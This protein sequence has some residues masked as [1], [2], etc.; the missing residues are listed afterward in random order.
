MVIN[1]LPSEYQ[2]VEYLES[3]GEE[4]IDSGV[5]PDQHLSFHCKFMAYS[6]S[7]P[8]FGNVF[9]SR[10]RSGLNE[11]QLTTYLNGII[12]V[13]AR[14]QYIGFYANVINTIDFDGNSIATVNGVQTQLSVLDELY[15]RSIYLFAIREGDYVRQL[16]SGRIYEL[17][18]GNIANFI[19]CYRK[20][21]SEPGMYDTVRNQFFTNSGTGRFLV[22]NDVSH[23]N[24]NLME[25]RR[26]ILLNTPHIKSLSDNSLNFKSDMGYFY[27]DFKIHFGPVQDLNGYY[28]PWPAGGGTIPFDGIFEAGSLDS[29]GLNRSLNVGLRTPGYIPIQK[30]ATYT[31]TVGS[32]NSSIGTI[33][34]GVSYYSTNDFVTER[35]RSNFN[36]Y[37]SI[38]FTIQSNE[39]IRYVRFEV[40]FIGSDGYSVLGNLDPSY[41]SDVQL[42]SNLPESNICPISGWDGVEVT[43]CG[44][45]VWDEQWE[46]GN[47]S[48]T[49]GA[50]LNA[51]D[52]IRSKN[53]I[54]ICP[55]TLYYASNVIIRF[56][57]DKN[58]NFLYYVGQAS[59]SFTTPANAYYMR[60]RTYQ[61]GATYNNDISINYLATATS[62]EPYQGET[63]EIPLVGSGKNLY[64]GTKSNLRS[65]IYGGRDNDSTMVVEDW[66]INP[67]TYTISF[68]VTN[69]T[70]H[71]SMFIS[72]QID[73]SW[74]QSN[75]GKVDS[76]TFTLP[77]GY[78]RLNIW[79]YTGDYTGFT[80]IQLEKGSVATEYEPYYTLSSDTVYGGTVDLLTGEL[81]VDRAMVDMGTMT[82]TYVATSYAVPIFSSSILGI[83]AKSS[84]KCITSI[85]TYKEGGW[86]LHPGSDK[87][88]GV[89][90]NNI[91]VAD[92]QYTSAAAFKTA[93]SGVQLVYELA[94]PQTYQL[95]PE[96]IRTLKGINN[97]FSNAN[98]NIDISFYSH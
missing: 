63:I 3:T 40:T 31:L 51:N 89:G 71:P 66:D 59:G 54:P 38:T 12:S 49:T 24:V 26:R 17:S 68:E 56:Y 45:N 75:K 55:S 81:T 65:V 94:T 69:M 76:F 95:T 48:D 35:I 8:G 29:K 37:R 67:G 25:S 91:N 70:E 2:E 16:Q 73:G 64:V 47:I 21:D 30:N 85:Y 23:S 61:Y 34:L 19:P 11:Y 60:F 32:Y 97:V 5:I 44:K 46:V 15:K 57:Y 39:N 6:S 62:Y 18:F 92:S 20:S 79:G 13:G 58:K 7:D 72:Y 74:V 4:W 53:Y 98:G 84:S 78:T 28:N 93:M 52:N 43:K 96:T 86:W 9:G 10:V 36:N 87:I 1:R 41:V 50:N 90:A 88:I 80:N 77:E 22:G 14:N 83:G 42:T 33:A 27:K 82:W